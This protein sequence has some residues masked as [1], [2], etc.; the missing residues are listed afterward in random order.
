MKAKS[1]LHYRLMTTRHYLLLQLCC[2]CDAFF[3]TFGPSY[4]P[5]LPSAE[6]SLEYLLLRVFAAVCLKKRTSY[7][8]PE[9]LSARS[10]L[11]CN[12]ASTNTKAILYMNEYI[13][14]LHPAAYRVDKKERKKERE[15]K[16]STPVWKT[17]SRSTE[18]NAWKFVRGLSMIVLGV[19]IWTS[20]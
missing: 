2:Y 3:W 18:L 8:L 7:H 15:R 11:A 1:I 6:P 17:R 16:S 14:N 13:T 20:L 12:R 10:L 5:R 19:G 4:A 9:S